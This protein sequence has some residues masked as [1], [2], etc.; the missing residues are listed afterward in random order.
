MSEL[1]TLRYINTN[2]GYILTA[3]LWGFGAPTWL[4]V[5][6]LALVVIESIL[7]ALVGRRV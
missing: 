5:S 2:L 4:W 6:C 3:L 1:Q 7:F